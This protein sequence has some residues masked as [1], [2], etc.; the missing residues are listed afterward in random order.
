MDVRMPMQKFAMSLNRPDHAGHHILAPQQPLGFRLETRPGTRGKLAQ[1]LAIEPG[2]N[3]QTLGNG[4]HDLPM[5]DRGTDF[6]G[7]VH[8]GQQGPLLVAGRTRAALLAGEGDEHLMLAV[9]A[10]NSGE[11]FLQVAALQKS[12]HRLLDDPAPETILGLIALVVDLLERI[13]VLVKKK[14]QIGSFRITWLVEG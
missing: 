7:H 13:K 1:Q 9:G 14:P 8:G 12:L 4:Q 5:G 10:A 3:S 6:F 2:V 11:A